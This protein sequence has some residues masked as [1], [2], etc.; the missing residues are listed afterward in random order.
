ML[1]LAEL[2]T[3]IASLE[4]QLHILRR[5]RNAFSGLC[6]LPAELV[7]RILAHSQRPHAHPD[8]DYTT[9]WGALDDSWVRLAMSCAHV[10]VIAAQE[11]TLWAFVQYDAKADRNT[12]ARVRRA[13]AL[14]LRVR[15]VTNSSLA[16]TKSGLNAWAARWLV[17]AS[18]AVIA[19]T[20][21][22]VAAPPRS[23]SVKA[24]SAL[25][26]LL[27]SPALI[28]LE[29]LDYSKSGFVLDAQFLGGRSEIL[30]SLQLEKPLLADT[31]PVLP[32][33]RKL[34]LI[35]PS[36]QD[37][38]QAVIR[39][40]RPARG[41]ELLELRDIRF[42]GDP[43]EHTGD[44]APMSLPM[45]AVL[46]VNDTTESITALLRALPMCPSSSFP[47]YGPQRR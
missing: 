28:H 46:Q 44:T 17:K 30:A 45:F 23:Q 36:L 35:D 8:T 40:I 20:S 22:P 5:Q 19:P 10:W 39:L 11:R 41:L 26:L 24:L 33:L 18:A 3:Q 34:R 25:H 1:T 14:P 21:V 12:D 27:R 32:G 31:L 2:D 38:I 42:W 29:A 4:Y 7:L 6:R 13:G 9:S 15:A 43:V 16:K 47:T 37:G